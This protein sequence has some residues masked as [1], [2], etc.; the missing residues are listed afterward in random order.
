MEECYDVLT[1]DRIPTGRTR[2]RGEP[3]GEGE[4]RS[5]AEI[6]VFHR[7]GRLMITRRHLQK[8]AHPGKWECTGGLVRAGET[9]REAIL[10][11][12]GEEIGLTFAPQGVRQ[13][14]TKLYRREYLDIFTA[15]TDVPAEQLLLQED[16]VIDARYVTWDELEEVRKSGL[17]IPD[18]YERIMEFRDRI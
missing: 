11:E 5:G 7:D 12:A 18:L 14:A 16:E 4:Y 9:T 17:L 3:L 10:R 2:R 15:V 8:D 13:I 6:W 1:V